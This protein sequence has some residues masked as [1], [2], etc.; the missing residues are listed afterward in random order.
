VTTG[1]IDWEVGRPPP[2]IA[3]Y[4]LL[5]DCQGSALVSRS[6]SIDWACLPRFDSPSVFGRVLGPDAGHWFIGPT[7]EAEIQRS[8]L[9]DTMVLRTVF[10]TRHGSVALTDACA[11]GPDER[12]HRI[13]L[14]SPHAILRV[15][16]G[17]EGEVEIDFDLALRPGYG[18]TAPVL[19][20]HA[21]GLRSQ[22]GPQAYVVTA[23]LALEVR[24]GTARGGAR[25]AAGERR[26][27]AL[28]M[29]SAWEEAPRPWSTQEVW[30]LLEATIAGWR[31]WSALHQS[32]QGPYAEAVRH[33]GRVLQA[34]TYAPTGAIVAAPTTSLPEVVGGSRNWDYRYCWVRDASFTMAALWV[35][36]CPDEARSFF[37]FL[38]TA[39][40]GALQGRSPLQIL[41]GIGAERILPEHALDH[42]PGYRGSRPVRIGNGAWN[43][44]Q[45]DVYGELL[46]AAD[47]LAEQV[48]EFAP[49]TSAFL[50]AVADT[51]A[52]RWEEPDQGIWEMRGEPRH[53]LYS[54]LICWAALDRAVGL[55]R[56]LGAEERVAGWAGERD[57]IRRAIE[58]LGWS[59]RAGAFAQSFGSDDLD[60]SSLTLP[61]VGFLP[62]DDPRIRAT[63]EA[64]AERLTD[65]RGFVYR[66]RSADGLAGQEG[67]FAIC[68]FWLVECLAMMGET[69]RAREIFERL[70]GC[71]NDVGLLSEE[72]DPATG[73]LLGNFPQAF[74]HIGL[75]N[76]AWAISRATLDEQALSTP[77]RRQAPGSG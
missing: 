49:V 17:L 42:L 67:S 11:L 51:A 4:A 25:I 62:P 63:V 71:A 26:A 65:A 9:P 54:K 75:V 52:A 64:T 70:L 39:A 76:A 27:F 59:E 35:A 60:A 58:D 68:T 30:A 69:E 34:L 50:V 10:R 56:R 33:S 6:G 12:G 73:E 45:L 29:V 13:G 5:S 57:R 24:T 22:G 72:I 55:A 14:H 21:G 40:G 47:L 48:G 77:R 28:R 18:L 44:S 41:Y 53:F 61:I 36:A 16:E 74:T 46:S 32:Y 43:Q 23:D 37:D 66:Y 19:V 15:L 7:E 20:S 31:S 3:D 2:A 8:Y 38:A 1:G